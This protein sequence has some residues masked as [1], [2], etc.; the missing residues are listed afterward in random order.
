MKKNQKTCK[1]IQGE[2]ERVSTEQ[3]KD[4]CQTCVWSLIGIAI[5]AILLTIL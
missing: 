3:Y 2:V 5:V 4:S 1:P